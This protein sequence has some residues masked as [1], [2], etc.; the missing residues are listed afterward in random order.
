MMKSIKAAYAALALV[1]ASAANATVPT[2]VEAVFTGTATDFGTIVGYG[3]TLFLVIVGGMIL[4]K[5][6]KKVVSKST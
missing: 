3:W 5:I 4:F 2:G 1:L 6:V